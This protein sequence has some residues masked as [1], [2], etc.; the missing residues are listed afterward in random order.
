MSLCYK[1]HKNV[2]KCVIVLKKKKKK[3]VTQMISDRRLDNHWIGA[4]K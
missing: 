4:L 3:I 1:C 2:T